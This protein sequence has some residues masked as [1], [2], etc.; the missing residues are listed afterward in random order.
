MDWLR[1]VILGEGLDL[2][3]M[4]RAAFSGEETQRPVTGSRELPVR[5][6]KEN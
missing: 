1:G 6:E 5:L 3:T 2:T 4:S